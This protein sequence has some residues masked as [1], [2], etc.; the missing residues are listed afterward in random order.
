M[1]NY[2]LTL[3]EYPIFSFIILLISDTVPVTFIGR[4][5]Q[6][7]N[8]YIYHD[9][10]SLSSYSFRTTRLWGGTVGNAV[11]LYGANTHH[12]PYGPRGGRLKSLAG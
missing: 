9:H 11:I 2:F 1:A 5:R 10:E 8:E 3:S 7:D 4:T 6:T 12:V